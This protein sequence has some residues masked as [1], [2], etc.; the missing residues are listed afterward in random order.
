MGLFILN[1]GES[2]ENENLGIRAVEFTP[3]KCRALLAERPDPSRVVLEFYR[4][5]DKQ[6]ICRVTVNG[7][8]SNTS[9]LG[10]EMCGERIAF[11]VI[12]VNGLNARDGWVSFDLRK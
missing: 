10:E 12:G 9:I 5:A 11:S 2:I 6:I 3:S 7:P 1:R 4:P 8:I